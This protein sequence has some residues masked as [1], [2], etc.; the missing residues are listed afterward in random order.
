MTKTRKID[1]TKKDFGVWGDYWSAKRN[2]Y[3]G[4]ASV[5][6]RIG[7]SD[8]ADGEDHLRIEFQDNVHITVENLRTLKYTIDSLIEQIDAGSEE[9]HCLHTNQSVCWEDVCDATYV[10]EGDDG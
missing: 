5:V 8:S 4:K 3:T 6:L 7:C 2:E 1:Y 9:Y 10:E